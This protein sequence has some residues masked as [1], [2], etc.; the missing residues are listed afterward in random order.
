[1]GIYGTINYWFEYN[2]KVHNTRFIRKTLNF[3]GSKNTRT[4][5]RLCSNFFSTR[6]TY[7]SVY[8]KNKAHDPSFQTAPRSC[9]EVLW[10]WSYEPSKM[11]ALDL[12]GKISK[13]SRSRNLKE[14]RMQIFAFLDSAQSK[15]Q[16]ICQFKKI[17]K[18]FCTLQT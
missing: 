6:E 9:L 11:S 7:H 1:M 13:I 8:I 4:F 18:Y 12:N 5:Q 17:L 10:F 14:Q 2:A 3:E 15:T 16:G